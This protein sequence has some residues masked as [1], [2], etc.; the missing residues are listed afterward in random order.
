[1]HH[2]AVEARLDRQRLQVAE[3]LDAAAAQAEEGGGED[4]AED[5][6][7]LDR[8]PRVRVVAVAELG[9][10]PRV[11]EVDG[12]ARGVD[13]GQLEGHLDAL[14]ARLAEVEDAADARLEAGLADR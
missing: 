4:E 7:P 5:G 9:P 2:H 1:A 13:L 3:V 10:R 11:E 12:D 6:D 14:L 8:L